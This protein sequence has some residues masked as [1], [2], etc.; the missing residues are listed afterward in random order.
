MTRKTVA[1]S[2]KT[3]PCWRKNLSV[4]DPG[5]RAVRLPEALKF[6]RGERKNLIRY[7]K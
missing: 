5:P 2:A 1:P 7:E 6:F 3:F 4:I